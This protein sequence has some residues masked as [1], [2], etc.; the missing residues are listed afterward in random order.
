ME[1]V[2][3]E[4]NPFSYLKNLEFK[5]A[6]KDYTC[7]PFEC[8]MPSNGGEVTVQITFWAH[9]GEPEVNLNF[10]VSPEKGEAGQSPRQLALHL[11]FVYRHDGG[12][13]PHL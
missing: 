7:G 9:Y 1:P 6:S 8:L 2:D 10:K 12:C 11:S 5:G 13:S 4:G 3:R